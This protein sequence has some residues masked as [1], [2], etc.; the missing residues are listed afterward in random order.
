M[1]RAGRLLDL[2]QLLRNRR[3]AVSAQD[4]AKATGVSLRTLYRDIESLRAQGADIA[5]EAGVGY[6]LRPGF[7][8][9]PLMLSADEVEALV[10][11]SRL[12]ADRAEGPLAEAARNAVAKIGAVLPLPLQAEL[13]ASHLLIGPRA[14]ADL[15][16]RLTQI[17]DAIHREMKVRIDYVDASGKISNRIIWPF[18][19]AFFSDVLLIIGWCE[20][21]QAFRNFRIDRIKDCEALNIRYGI[22]RSVLLSRWRI[23]ENIPPNSADKN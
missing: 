2:L 21:R 17:R 8:L 5:G 14:R 18:A 19:L 7:I 22:A 11:G 12:V 9:P 16:P 13:A 23:A 4:L 10:L 20:H 3:S 6:I 1:S 15:E